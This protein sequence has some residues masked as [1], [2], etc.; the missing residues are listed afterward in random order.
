MLFNAELLIPTPFLIHS[1][2]GREYTIGGRSSLPLRCLGCRFTRNHCACAPMLYIFQSYAKTVPSQMKLTCVN[3]HPWQRTH[4]HGVW[5]LTSTAHR[6]GSTGRRTRLKVS[7]KFQIVRLLV[8]PLP[9]PPPTT[10][11][12]HIYTPFILDQVYPRRP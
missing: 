8:C 5:R 2:V 9:P 7:S 4:G 11:K 1:I 10:T 3:Q 6:V 12:I